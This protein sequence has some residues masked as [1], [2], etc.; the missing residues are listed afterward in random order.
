MTFLEKSEEQRIK[1]RQLMSWS[2]ISRY[3]MKIGKRYEICQAD[4]HM[5]IEADQLPRSLLMAEK[6]LQACGSQWSTLFLHLAY[7]WSLENFVKRRGPWAWAVRMICNVVKGSSWLKIC[8]IW[9]GSDSWLWSLKCW[10]SKMVSPETGNN[11]LFG[12]MV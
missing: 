3:S 4:Q 8:T 6:P 2:W 11:N 1:L 10:H 5:S 9:L 12:N 7:G